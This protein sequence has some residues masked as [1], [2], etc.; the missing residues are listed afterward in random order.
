MPARR[1]NKQS[2]P[3]I[4]EVART[5][6][7]AVGTVS[8]VLNANRTVAQD[9]RERVLKAVKRL[10]YQPNS[11]A[12]S[13]RL[14]STHAIGCI[15]TDIAQPVAAAMLAAA[16]RELWTAGYAMLIAGT[17]QRAE[18]ER[19]ILAFLQQR[20]VDGIITVTTNDQEPETVARLRQ[21]DVPVALWER[22][23][24]AGFDT[25]LTDHA[26]G[27]AH[28]TRYLLGLGHRRIA[29][30]AG[31]SGT[32]P[33]REQVRGYLAALAEAK[34][35]RDPALALSS[36]NFGTREAIALL[37][38]ADRPSA[39]IANIHLIP[40]LLRTCRELR[41]AVP[42]QLALLS[43]GDSDTIEAFDPP[44]TAIRGDGQLVGAT[45][46]RLVLARLA[47]EGRQATRRIIVPTE[48][49]IRQSCVNLGAARAVVVR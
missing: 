43:I 33:G 40:L 49:V 24:G 9:V 27:A 37:D 47:G 23:V 46:A 13:M 38:R 6:K 42:R 8:R 36:D 5:A 22:D 17:H 44:I 29:I 12:R 1:P 21:L 31:H 28:A 15:V 4:K 19:E 41:V 11:V 26:N 25:V 45:A 16:E 35:P 32:W 10:G 30:I 14:K 3:T 39:V 7:V 2:P 34:T 18:R 48:L 20:R